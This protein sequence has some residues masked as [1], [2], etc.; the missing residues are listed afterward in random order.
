MQVTLSPE[1]IGEALNH[2]LFQATST[3]TAAANITNPA[4]ASLIASLSK[5]PYIAAS[6]LIQLVLGIALGY[7]SV[8]ALKYILAFIGIL[9]LGAFLNV[10]S[11]GTGS[12]EQALQQ[13]YQQFEQVKPVLKQMAATLGLLTVG[14]VSIGYI[15]GIIIGF[16]KK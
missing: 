4:L 9:V 11:L 7:V 8:K 3:T 2:L 6:V 14:P 13:Y 5:N 12:V 16:S 15:I 1:V 10:W